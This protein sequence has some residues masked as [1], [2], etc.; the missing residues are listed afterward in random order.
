[1]QH[2][3]YWHVQD[4]LDVHAHIAVAERI[5]LYWVF[6]GG[7]KQS[8]WIIPQW[9]HHTNSI[10]FLSWS[11]NRIC[12]NSQ[13]EISRKLSSVGLFILSLQGNHVSGIM[14]AKDAF[15]VNISIKFT[16][17]GIISREMFEVVWFF[18]SSINSSLYGPKDISSSSGSAETNIKKSTE[19]MSFVT[20]VLKI[21]FLTSHIYTTFIDGV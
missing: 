17:F 12:I 16:T 15:S 4:V 20:Y 13:L 3:F 21:V 9:S 11:S 18:H 1:M 5:I 10:T 2:F 6:N 8:K 19:S 7:L 14:F